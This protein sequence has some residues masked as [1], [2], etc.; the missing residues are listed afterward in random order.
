VV[1]SGRKNQVMLPPMSYSVSPD[2]TDL[3]TGLLLGRRITPIK[4]TFKDFL[5]DLNRQI[6]TPFRSVVRVDPTPGLAISERFIVKDPGLSSSLQTFLEH[7]AEYVSNTVSSEPVVPQQFYRGYSGG[8]SAIEQNLDVRRR[9]TDAVLSAVVSLPGTEDPNAPRFVLVKGYAGSGKTVLIK[10]VAWDIANSFE[11]LS[12]FLRPE[13][14]L[15]YET[16]RACVK[17][18]E[19]CTSV[20]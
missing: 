13:G 7:D 19:I 12:L 15:Q 2:F 10:R 5:L 20:R 8:W 9:L 17:S 3:E 6:P 1:L 14:R 4:C 18:P 16:L 11:G